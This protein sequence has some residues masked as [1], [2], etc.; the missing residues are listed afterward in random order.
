M[1]RITCGLEWT[2]FQPRSLKKLFLDHLVLSGEEY[3]GSETVHD[4]PFEKAI[5]QLEVAAFKVMHCSRLF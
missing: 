4:K 3:I 2:F 1:M 5:L